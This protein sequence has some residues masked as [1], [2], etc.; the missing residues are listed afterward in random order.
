MSCLVLPSAFWFCRQLLGFA[1]SF[2]F[3]RELFVIAVSPRG[4]MVILEA[5]ANAVIYMYI[6]TYIH[7][8]IH[9]YIVH[10]YIQKS[11]MRLA[12]GTGHPG[13]SRTRLKLVC[14]KAWWLRSNKTLPALVTIQVHVNMPSDRTLAASK[15]CRDRSDTVVSLLFRN[16]TS[17][18]LRFAHKGM[19]AFFRPGQGFG[20]TVSC[21]SIEWVFFC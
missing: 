12:S 15:T 17:E 20:Y 18:L 11:Q 10:I 3:C 19:F 13:W 16:I 5:E 14:C 2:C 1:V 4:S 8:Y 9:T 7:T 21:Q 6:Y